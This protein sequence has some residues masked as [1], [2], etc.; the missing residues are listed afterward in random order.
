[1]G[2]KRKYSPEEII[3]KLREAEVLLSQGKTVREASRHLGIAEQTYY[4]WRKEY[5]GLNVTQAGKLKQ[6]EKENARL[7]QLVADLSLDNAILKEVL[8]KK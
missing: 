6:L 7:K 2:K 4:R 8:S 5:G 1:M 3:M